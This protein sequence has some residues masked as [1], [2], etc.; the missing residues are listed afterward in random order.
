[1]KLDG[2]FNADFKFMLLVAQE[3]FQVVNWG[4]YQHILSLK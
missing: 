4:A 3:S 2:L 1:M